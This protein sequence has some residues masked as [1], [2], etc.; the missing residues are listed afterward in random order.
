MLSILKHVAGGFHNISDQSQT[1][2][3]TRPNFSSKEKN[4]NELFNLINTISQLWILKISYIYESGSDS[5]SDL[6]LKATIL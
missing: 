6:S 3:E 1:A 5:V 4:I 2:A